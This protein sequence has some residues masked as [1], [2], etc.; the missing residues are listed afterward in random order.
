MFWPPMGPLPWTLANADGSLR[1]TNKAAFAREF[2]KNVSPAETIP[3]PSV[4]GGGS[5]TGRH[6][7]SWRWRFYNWKAHTQLKVE[8][9]QL[10]GTHIV[11]CGDSTTGR[12][13]H[14]RKAQ[15]QLKVD[16]CYWKAQTQLKVEFLQLEGTN[17]VEGRVST[18]GRHK[19]SWR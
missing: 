18:T 14:S 9:L 5:T 4:E 16:V 19:H 10:E 11:E 2:E 12:H 6:K 15:T 17:T 3:T 13:T 1:K 7:H 8:V